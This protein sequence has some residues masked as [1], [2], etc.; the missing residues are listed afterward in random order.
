MKK[1]MSPKKTPYS[2]HIQDVWCD[3]INLKF[4]SHNLPFEFLLHPK[5][6]KACPRVCNTLTQRTFL[7]PKDLIARPCRT[8]RTD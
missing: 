5:A 3:L 2:L 8:I 1:C 7:Y 6:L 4:I